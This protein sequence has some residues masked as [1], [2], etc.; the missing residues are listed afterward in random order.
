MA[1]MTKDRY[2]V[3][4][5]VR[6]RRVVV[7][8]GGSAVLGQVASLVAAGALVSVVAPEVEAAIEDRA[9]RGDLTWHDRDWH[10]DDLEDAWLVVAS[11]GDDRLFRECEQRRLWCIPVA[12]PAP[13]DTTGTP[14][15]VTLVGGGPGD[16]GLLTLAGMDALRAAD[17]IVVDRLAPLA[18]LGD[19]PNAP[20]I[21]DVSKIPGGR[22]TAQ[23]RINALLLEH[24][25]RGAHVVRFKGGDS[26]VFGRG[27]EEVIACTDAGVPVHVIPGV[28]SAVAAPELAGI[29]VTHRGVSQGFTVVSGHLPPGH[30]GSAVDY[31]A[32][33]RSGT[34]LVLLMAVANLGAIADALLEAGLPESTPCAVVAD[35]AMASQRSIRSRLGTVA[36][37]ARDAGVVSPAVTVIGDVAALGAD[38][39]DN[40]ALEES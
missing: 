39:H 15:R 7:A 37:D 24:A 3:P 35:A 14:G 32:L 20:Q 13:S 36:A 2:A 22:S 33:A 40:H 4:L 31:A 17:V 38:A 8:G 16:P 10:P 5:P 9:D 34:T 6:G 1:R 21:I 11:E 12:E 28:T 19:L 29:P 30:P 25:A 23:D 26:F 27:G 18:V